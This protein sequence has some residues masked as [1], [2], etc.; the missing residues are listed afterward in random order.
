MMLYL[1]HVKQLTYVKQLTNE[2]IHIGI[3]YMNKIKVKL[4]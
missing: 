4:I 3:P 1:S 2:E